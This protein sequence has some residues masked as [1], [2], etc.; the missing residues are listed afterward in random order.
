MFDIEQFLNLDDYVT[1]MNNEDILENN[2]KKFDIILMNPPYDRSLHLKFLE[3]TIQI[4]DNV[5]SIQPVR[6]LEEGVARY[7]KNS[8]YNKYKESIS[9]HIKDIDIIS[10]E[11]SDIYFLGAH[12]S[13]ELGIYICDEKGGFDYNKLSLDS[14]LEKVINKMPSSL[15]DHIEFSIPKLSVVT[16]LICGGDK[17]RSKAIQYWLDSNPDKSIYDKDGKRLDN[18]LTFE[19][20]RKKTAW[21]NV[22]VRAEQNNIKFN[23]IEECK[24][25]VKYT[26]TDFFNYIFNKSTLDVHVQSKYLPFMD[27]YTH[28]WTDEMLYKYFDI[29]KEEQKEIKKFLYNE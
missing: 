11:D 12:F 10:Q 14:I 4:A 16:S 27:D 22:K 23:S 7:K 1:D 24:N 8:A 21:G 13:M 2:G 26:R 18:G 20:N 5:V 29:T 9:K 6:W 17:G 25:F 3:K 15:D 19:E 28:K